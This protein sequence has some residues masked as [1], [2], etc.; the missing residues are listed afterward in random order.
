MEVHIFYPSTQDTE[1]GGSLDLCEFLVAKVEMTQE[2][3]SQTTKKLHAH[4]IDKTD[5][6]R[7]GWGERN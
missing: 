5:P 1:A 7:H 2:N 6:F 4:V 3:N